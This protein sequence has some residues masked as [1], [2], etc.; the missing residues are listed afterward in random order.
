MDECDSP[1]VGA[2]SGS[3]IDQANTVCSKA[4]K[5]SFEVR[6]AIGDVVHPLTSFGHEFGDRAV[7]VGRLDQFNVTVA[8]V[9]RDGNH[10]LF[11][12]LE[13]LTRGKAE[14]SVL[15]GCAFDIGHDES[16]MMQFIPDQT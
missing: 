12:H 4:S 1:T 10:T 7:G 8:G 13:S 2:I 3:G 15:R 9:K 11:S 14:G 5:S 16:D 6:H